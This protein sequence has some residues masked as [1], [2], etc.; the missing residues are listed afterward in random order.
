MVGRPHFHEE[1][2][3][4]ELEVLGMGELA[5]RAVGRAVDA[6]VNHDDEIAELVIRE[7]DEI[8]DRYLSIET[9]TLQVM[10]LQT[11]VAT[12]LRLL[13]VILH[14]NLHLERI[15]DQAVNIAKTYRSV[16]DLPSSPTILTHVQ[17]MGDVVRPMIRTAMEA[18]A[19][20]DLNLCLR[21]PEMDDPVDRLN[22]G[23]YR[24]VAALAED[25]PLLNWGLRMILV[26]RQLERVG[27]HAV[28][29]GEQVGF[30]LTGEFR[31]FTDA[32]HPTDVL[33]NLG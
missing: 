6:V 4:L 31:E 10:A 30:L 14:S 11:P 12:D 16:K 13:S 23:M 17:E 21:L 5:E 3:Q 19:R 2:E 1:L 22:L 15:G 28:D 18:F 26:A 29:I 27:D 8:D 20:R 33:P 32:S 9:R 25:E 7:D 24:E